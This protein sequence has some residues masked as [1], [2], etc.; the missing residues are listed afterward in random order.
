MLSVT[1][2][3]TCYNR[4][5]CTKRCI[6]TIDDRNFNIKYVVVDDNSKD[7]TYQMLMGRQKDLDLVIL[8]GNGNLFWAGGMRKAIEFALTSESKT[9][10]Y[11][12]VNDDVQ[13]FPH[14]L[15]KTINQ[16]I[17]CGDTVIAGV[18]CDQGGKETYG[19]I[20]YD[21]GIHYETVAAGVAK[22]VDAFNCNFVLL[23]QKQFFETGNFDNRFRHVLADFDYGL[24]LSRSGNA[25]YVSKE[26]VGICEKN[27]KSNTWM[28]STLSR[29]ARIKKKETPKGLPHKEWFYFLKKHFGWKVAI[30][31]SITPYLKI[32]LKK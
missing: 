9:D 15:E 20:I 25:V 17:E 23:P 29:R 12:M 5:N 13:F 32:F 18:T 6:E 11:V 26:F 19:G 14:V 31:K 21:Q 24:R 30:I 27:T 28:D 22:M 3:L 10:Y 4:V 16:S 7:G 8:K 2:L 1:I